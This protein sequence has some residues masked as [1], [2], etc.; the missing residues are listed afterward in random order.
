VF[1]GG[2]QWG[3]GAGQVERVDYDPNETGVRAN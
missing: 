2:N 3:G 1:T